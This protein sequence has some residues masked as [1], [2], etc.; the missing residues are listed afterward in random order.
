LKE[1]DAD[2]GVEE[3][4][5]LFL[6]DS[7]DQEIMVPI[8]TQ[9]EQE[10]R[11]NRE[12]RVLLSKTEGEVNKKVELAKFDQLHPTAYYRLATG[13]VQRELNRAENR[14]TLI[15]DQSVKDMIEAVSKRIIEEGLLELLNKEKFTSYLFGHD[16]HRL[17]S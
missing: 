13:K 5:N 10:A 7:F 14:E 3:Y 4:T 11:D 2:G 16:E 1:D 8:R 9:F 12:R 6:K 15:D 17:L